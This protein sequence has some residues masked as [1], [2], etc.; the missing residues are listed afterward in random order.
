MCYYDAG[1]RGRCMNTPIVDF[2]KNYIDENVSRFHMPGHKGKDV[3]GFEKYDI[4]EIDGADVLSHAE[5]IIL[6]SE[7]NATKIF[8][9]AHTFYVTEGSTRAI[10]SMLALVKNN[11]KKTVILATRNV[12]KAFVNACALLDYDV[13]FIV[14]NKFLHISKC[15]ISCDD[16]KN[17]IIENK[18]DA[19]YVTSPDYLGN[20]LDIKGI[21]KVCKKYGVPL[22]VDNAHGSYLKFLGMHP[23]D[24]GA[25]V[26]SDSA[27]KTL[28]VLTGGAYLHIS[29]DAPK[30]FVKN[31]RDKIALFSST[32]PSYLVLQS[33]DMCNK[34]LND[35]YKEKLESCIQKIESVKNFLCEKGFFIE[36]GETLKIVINANKSGYFGYELKDI[37][38][39]EKIEVEFYDDTFLVLMITP[40]NSDL[41][42]ERLKN[43]FSNISVKEEV[44]QNTP[45]LKIPSMKISVK[46]AV[47]A[48][49]ETV[50]IKDSV[51]RICASNV[52]SCPPAI[53]L[54]IPGEEITKETVSLL[55]H[56]K[57]EKINVVKNN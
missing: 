52:I 17:G 13:R 47:F 44:I 4:T 14:P 23:M 10:S 6:E 48:E 26:C 20:V 22:L 2:V 41:D 39:K 25:D 54:V 9:T 46:D 7:E 38:R 27:H 33:L 40:E 50:D 28:P 12:H 15:E 53:P 49:Y 34:Y 30:R 43:A 3:L 8:D 1:G 5:G 36:K 11:D 24:L 29:K 51:G 18:P 56:Y 16:I 19:V 37:L 42:F 57:I 55:K 32:S 21:S 35:G 31:A 45:V